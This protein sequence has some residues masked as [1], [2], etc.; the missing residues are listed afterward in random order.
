M[1]HK[2]LR[3]AGTLADDLHAAVQSATL[4]HHR[5]T[6][7]PRL[8]QPHRRPEPHLPAYWPR[9]TQWTILHNAVLG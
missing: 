6:V 4:R 5:F 2:L 7:T 8:A 1:T 9:P 3:A